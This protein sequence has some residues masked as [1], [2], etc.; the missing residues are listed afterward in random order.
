MTGET[1]H[2]EKKL[3]LGAEAVAQGAID[4]GISG[5]YAYPGI[6]KTTEYIQR[7]LEGNQPSALPLG[8][9]REDCGLRG[10]TGCLLP[11]QAKPACMAPAGLNVA[12]D[13]FMNAISRGARLVLVVA[14]DFDAAPHKR[15]Q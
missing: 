5:V 2:M 10:G 15:K 11:G 9:Q 4:A 6:T 1:E 12:A 3:L 14:D 7:V 13:A 8:N